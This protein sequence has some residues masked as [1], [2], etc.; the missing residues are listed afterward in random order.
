MTDCMSRNIFSMVQNTNTSFRVQ[1]DVTKTPNGT[2]A[3]YTA[4]FLCKRTLTQ[5][6]YDIHFISGTG[7]SIQIANA[8]LGYVDVNFVAA[9]TVDLQSGDYFWEIRLYNVSEAMDTR[10]PE[11]IYGE[12]FLIKAL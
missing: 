3:G 2:L 4:E 10:S 11:I 1:F 12:L 5:T 7:T 9:D 6:T 8:S